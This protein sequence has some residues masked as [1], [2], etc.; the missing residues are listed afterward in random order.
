MY[1]EITPTNNIVTFRYQTVPD[2]SSQII[3]FTRLKQDLVVTIRE[4]GGGRWDASHTYEEITTALS[5]GVLVRIVD[6]TFKHYAT[7]TAR[8][9]YKYYFSC[10]DGTNDSICTYEVSSSDEWFMAVRPLN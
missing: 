1:I 2:Y 5:Q 6:E 10:Y 8:D 3:P 4:I 7:I 9:T